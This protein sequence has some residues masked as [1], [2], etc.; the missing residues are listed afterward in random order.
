MHQTSRN[1]LTGWPASPFDSIARWHPNRLARVAPRLGS[2][3]SVAGGARSVERSAHCVGGDARVDRHQRIWCTPA[4]ITGSRRPMGGWAFFP[5]E[6]DFAGTEAAE[7]SSQPWTAT[8]WTLNSLREWG[9]DASVLWERRTA[10]L[11]AEN[12]R[13]EYEGRPYWDG[14][15]DCCI[16][17]W[18]VANGVW[19]DVCVDELADWFVRH[20]LPDGGWNCE[21]IEGSTRSSFHSTLN[22]L[23]GLLAYEIATGER[24]RRARL[25][26]PVRS[27]CCSAVCSGDSRP[28][29]RWGPGSAGLR[30]RSGGVTTCSTQPTTS[31]KRRCR[32]EMSLIREWRTRSR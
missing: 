5:A 2:S 27:T 29:N 15:V 18:T 19:L 23:K 7:Q 24:M 30:T 8:T 10:E 9:L 20:Q 16:N 1:A 12:C 25:G 32:M 14:E 22:S 28:A 11:L 17:A 31:A 6:F 3:D 13:W 21:W 4:F 26:D